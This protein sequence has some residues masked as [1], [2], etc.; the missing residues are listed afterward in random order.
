MKVLRCQNKKK[1]F[2]QGLVM[3]RT[4]VKYIYF[5]STCQ[6][7]LVKRNQ[8]FQPLLGKTSIIRTSTGDFPIQF[9]L[10]PAGWLAATTLVHC[11]NFHKPSLA[12]ML[13][14]SHKAIQVRVCYSIQDVHSHQRSEQ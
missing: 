11:A 6:K 4:E 12:C 3:L 7:R 14:N 5:R 9:P 8:V 1:R 10:T 2:K 13:F